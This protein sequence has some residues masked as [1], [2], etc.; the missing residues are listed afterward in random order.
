MAVRAFW[1]VYTLVWGRLVG[2]WL[3]PEGAEVEA[4]NTTLWCY[5]RMRAVRACACACVL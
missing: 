2:W 5:V 4:T 3:G 1:G